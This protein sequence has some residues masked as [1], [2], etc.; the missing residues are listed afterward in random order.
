MRPETTY[1]DL[2]DATGNTGNVE[3]NKSLY[4]HPTVYSVDRD[5]DIHTKV[6][7]YF[8]SSY[9]IWTT[10]QAKAFPDGFQVRRGG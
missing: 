2:R 4:W 9:Y 3:E 7:L 6:D 1:Q 8:G 10:G 5:T